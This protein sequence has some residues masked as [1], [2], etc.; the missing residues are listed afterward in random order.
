[1]S[2][3]NSVM[4]ANIQV[5]CCMGALEDRCACGDQEKIL[6][7]YKRREFGLPPMTPPQREWCLDE[8]GSV[9]GYTRSEWIDMDDDLLA[10]GVLSAWTDYCRDKGLL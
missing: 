9:E 7:A 2:T 10:S 3:P 6:R 5:P 4:F 1:M 8:I